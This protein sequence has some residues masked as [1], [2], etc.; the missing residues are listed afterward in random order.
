MCHSRHE[1]KTIQGHER[2]TLR[3]IRV[4]VLKCGSTSECSEA[5]Q[6]VSAPNKLDAQ[7]GRPH[8]VLMIR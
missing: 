8:F 1:L 6:V 2:L 5:K 7:D 4:M 3:D